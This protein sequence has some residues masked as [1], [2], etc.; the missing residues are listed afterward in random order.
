MR[1]S[2]NRRVLS[3]DVWRGAE[4]WKA[5]IVASPSLWR[6]IGNRWG[7]DIPNSQARQRILE[8]FG[9]THNLHLAAELD[10]EEHE[11]VSVQIVPGVEDRGRE[12]D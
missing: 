11:L 2:R 3:I 6:Y 9:E 5:Q 4:G 12:P 8:L 1:R 10:G 7:Q